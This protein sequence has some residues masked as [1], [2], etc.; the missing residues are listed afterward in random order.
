M[1]FEIRPRDNPGQVEILIDDNPIPGVYNVLYSHG[2]GH[3]A[4]IGLC[5]R[6]H[7]VNIVEED[8]D[9][10]LIVEGRHFRVIEEISPGIRITDHDTDR[11]EPG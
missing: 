4:E 2:V 5:I 6:P 8:A 3:I 11:G 10:A 7:E 9:V 1:K